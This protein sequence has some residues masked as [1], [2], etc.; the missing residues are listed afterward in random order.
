MYHRW[1]VG[2]IVPFFTFSALLGFA[3]YA[4]LKAAAGLCDHSTLGT[5]FLVQPTSIF[6]A[7]PSMFLGMVS[8][9]IPLAWLYR[10]LLRDRYAGLETGRPLA[11]TRET[12]PYAEVKSI[13]QRATF[14]AP[15]GNIVHRLHYV[16]VFHDGTSWS[17]REGLRDPV[18]DMDRQ[19]VEFVSRRSGRSI[20]ERP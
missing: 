17:T 3:W 19:I 12:H 4:A 10:W 13:E 2:S 9:A 8:S 16:I 18:P 14:R 11:W 5:R 20:V 1:E 7:I 15:N 6:W